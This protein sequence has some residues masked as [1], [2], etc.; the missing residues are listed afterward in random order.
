MLKKITPRLWILIIALVISIYAINLNP[1]ASGIEITNVEP[2]SLEEQ[3]GI[4]N[5][6]ILKSVNDIEINTIADYYNSILKYSNL[7]KEIEL[8]TDKGIYN[9]NAS[10][11]IGFI[12]DNLTII[13]TREPSLNIKEKIISI[14]KKEI[15]DIEDFNKAV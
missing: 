10:E 7:A 9:Y 13:S 3:H 4:N 14:K 2:G 6:E 1:W 8:K 12:H 11:D 5:G 15:K